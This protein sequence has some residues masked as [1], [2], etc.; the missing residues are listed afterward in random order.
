MKKLTL[1]EFEADV[2]SVVLNDILVAR[3]IA[4]IDCGDSGAFVVMEEPEYANLRD[5]L[6]TLLAMKSTIENDTFENSELESMV[7]R[8]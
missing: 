3:E 6:V 1:E 5:A 7:I 4:R 8:M 2:R